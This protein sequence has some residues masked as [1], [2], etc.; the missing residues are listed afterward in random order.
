MLKKR[1]TFAKICEDRLH[2]SNQSELYCI[3]GIDLGLHCHCIQ[4]QKKDEKTNRYN[5]I[6]QHGADSK[7]CD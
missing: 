4:K 6:R 1:C 5:G 7:C 3:D 2:L